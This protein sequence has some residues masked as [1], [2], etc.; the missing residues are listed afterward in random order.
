MTSFHSFFFRFSSSTRWMQKAFEWESF[1]TH[2]FVQNT[3]WWRRNICHWNDFNSSLRKVFSAK[4]LFAP[5]LWT[6]TLRLSAWFSGQ[7]N[8][9]NIKTE[10]FF[11]SSLRFNII[12]QWAFRDFYSFKCGAIFT[13]WKLLRGTE[14]GWK[15]KMKQNHLKNSYRHADLNLLLERF[16]PKTHWHAQALIG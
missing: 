3:S 13:R 16:H 1:F 4:I 14:R 8:M 15:I 2:R 12:V 11:S 6:K 9:A 5:L 10:S 7:E